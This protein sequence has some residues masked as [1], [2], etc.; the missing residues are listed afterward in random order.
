MPKKPFILPFLPPKLDYT[1]IFP[2]IIKTRDIVARY[3]EAVK[4]LPNPKII[5]R[6][7]ETKE[8]LLSSR[9]EG[10]QATLEEVLMFDAQ[11]LKSQDDEKERDYREI[12]N[13]RLAIEQGQRLLKNS[14]LAE[15]LI[16]ELHKILLSSTRGRNKNP[17]EFRKNQVHIGPYGASIER[18]TFVPPQPQQ[19]PSLFSNLE[20]YLHSQK[21]I[22]P[23]V[24]IAIAHYQ[25]EA[26]HP[27]L[28]GNGRIGRLLVPLFLYE[29]KVTAYPNIYVSEFLEKHRRH[30]YDLLRCVSEDGDWMLW[31]KFFLEAIYE[32]TKSTLEKV[33]KIE[34][35][36]KKLRDLTPQIHSV[37][38]NAFI[39][40]I[41][42]S[43]SFTVKTL[44]KTSKIANSQTAYTLIEKFLA[45]KIIA[46]IDPRRERNK[47][48]IFSDLYKIIK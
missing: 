3:D 7:F 38:A 35:L 41:F 21:E 1:P 4:R 11:N 45:L 32:Q 6:S 14:P 19:I 46:D 22:D 33:L 24:Q 20:K 40:A 16:K 23:I 26:I 44:Q 2:Q 25:F 18:A 34:K 12:F 27:F 17:G 9:I 48:Y 28:D 5:Q 29:K 47:I 10:T 39:D 8:A 43:P 37:Y 36:Y 31:I 30:Y 13:Y 15:N 42:I